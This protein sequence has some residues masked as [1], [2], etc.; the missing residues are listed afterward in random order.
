MWTIEQSASR[1]AIFVGITAHTS[2]TISCGLKVRQARLQFCAAAGNVIFESYRDT[3]DVMA[4]GASGDRAAVVPGD[5]AGAA[6]AD[7]G[8]WNTAHLEVS[9][10]GT[11][12]LATV[13]CGVAQANDLTHIRLQVG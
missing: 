9:S 11:D 8:D 13:G 3:V 5:G 1:S 6:I 4:S 12:H 2:G 7:A 10:T